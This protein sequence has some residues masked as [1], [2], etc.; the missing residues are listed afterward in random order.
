MEVSCQLDGLEIYPF[1][2]P[3]QEGGWIPQE[4]VWILWRTERS[5]GPGGNQTPV[6]WLSSP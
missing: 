2:P 4:L 3:E 1:L 5:L 6:P